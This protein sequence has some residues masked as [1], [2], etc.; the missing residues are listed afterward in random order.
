M[1]TQRHHH[2]AGGLAVALAFWWWSLQPSMLPRT[3]SAQGAVSGLSA[4]V[5]YLLGTLAGY[6]VAAL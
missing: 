5:G 3:P 2:Q 6:G 4:A 1:R